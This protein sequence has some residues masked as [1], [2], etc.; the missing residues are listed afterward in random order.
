MIWRRFLV[1][2]RAT[3]KDLEE[4]MDVAR[5]YFKESF[6]GKNTTY[7]EERSREKFSYYLNDLDTFVIDIN[8]IV[9]IAVLAMD[10]VFS[11]DLTADYEFFFVSRDCR[12]TGVSRLLQ[13]ACENFA[14]MSGARIMC[15][16]NSSDVHDGF[17]V[18][19]FKKYKYQ[20]LGTI[21]VKAL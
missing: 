15:A 14:K 21:M 5:P 13:E 20:K 9:A 4:V 16:A 19:L 18:N 3:I 11:E 17:W 2:R 7:S 1:V 10:Y 6:W 12:G 8:G